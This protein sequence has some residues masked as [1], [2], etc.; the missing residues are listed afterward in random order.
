MASEAKERLVHLRIRRQDGPDR[1]ESRRWEEFKVPYLPRMNVISALQ[2]IQ[3]DPRTADGKGVAP[4]AWEAV[5]L[6]EVC[7]ACTMVINGRVRQAC[8]ALVDKLAPKGEPITVEPMSKFPLVRDLMVDRSRMFED[9]KRVRAWIQV[10]G[11][12][13]LGPGPRESQAAQEERYPLSRCM[14]CGCCVEACPQYSATP[15]F[16]GA[17]AINLVRLYNLHPTGAMQKVERLESVM[18]EGGVQDCGKSQ[19]CVEVCP[20]EIPLVDSIAAVSRDATKQMLFGW[21]L[22]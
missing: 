14:T 4:V 2:Q 15:G 5:C 16:V 12:H 3:K 8:S 7:G 20:K 9:M 17:F 21:L 11:S 6:E 13:E 1:P 22:K 10:D 18:G 19:N